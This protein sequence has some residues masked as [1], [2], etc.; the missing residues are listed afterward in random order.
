MRKTL[1]T[2]STH[3]RSLFLILTLIMSSG[4]VVTPAYAATGVTDGPDVG[5]N[6]IM[7]G[8]CLK[9]GVKSNGT[10]GIG[11][12]TTPGIQYDNTC[13]GTFNDSYDFLTPGAPFEFISVVADGTNFV[14]N[15][16]DGANG[17][18]TGWDMRSLTKSIS[19]KAGIAYRGTTVD[20]RVVT[21][22]EDTTNGLMMENDVRFDNEDRI[23]EITTYI[24]NTRES[25]IAELYIGRGIDSDAV[26][27]AGDSS[28]TNNAR[29]YSI[30]DGKFLVFSETTESKAVMGYYTAQ[31]TPANMTNTG[32]SDRWSDVAA[33]YFVAP[34]AG[35]GDNTIGIVRKFTSVA[36]GAT[37]SF[38]YAY[39][40]GPSAFSALDAAVT[41]G[42]AG[43]PQ[44]EFLGVPSRLTSHVHSKTS[45][46]RS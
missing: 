6:M 39:I 43:G 32:I 1:V 11:L 2:L 17:N 13:T 36:P 9:I 41:K 46:V 21:H 24:T 12:V 5:T 14:F 40:F 44:G 26:V 15:N 22:V 28:A 30:V 34:D 31:D 19:N 38:S 8:N 10:L 18:G 35:N 33:D 37:V 3:A 20:N 42:A 45:V 29:G 7:E 16:M 25:A 27:T 23:I 4:L